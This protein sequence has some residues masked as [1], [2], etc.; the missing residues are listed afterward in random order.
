MRG[1]E[2]SAVRVPL[3]TPPQQTQLRSLNQIFRA[4][5]VGRIIVQRVRSVERKTEFGEFGDVDEFPWSRKFVNVTEF[6]SWWT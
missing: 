6:V 1:E 4:E 5:I 2:E 3:G